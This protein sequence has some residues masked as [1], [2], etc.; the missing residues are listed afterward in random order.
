MDKVQVLLSLGFEEAG[1]W[2][3]DENSLSFRLS[4]HKNERNI[5]YAFVAQGNVKYIGKTTQTLYKRMNGFKNPGPTQSTN[6]RNHHRI[7]DL[8]ERGIRVGIL[9][10]VQKQPFTYEGIRVNL[11][12]GLE[13]GLIEHVGPEWNQLGR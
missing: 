4:R 7:V 2:I 3:L 11:A 10:F 1:E 8:L 12:A 6:I 13:D 9:V 5:L